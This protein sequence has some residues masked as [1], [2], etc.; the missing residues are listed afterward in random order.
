M[1]RGCCR[2]VLLRAALPLLVGLGVLALTREAAAA[3][4]TT[5]DTLLLA[6]TTDVE[7]GVSPRGAMIRSFLFPGWGQAAAGSYTRGGVFFAIQ[8]SSWYMLL[9]TIARYHQAQDIVARKT[10]IATDSLDRLIAT[11]T[12]AARRLSDPSNY[13]AALSEYPGMIRARALVNSRRQQRQDWITYTLF[14]TLIS[15]VD[16]YVNAHLK[17]FPGDIMTEARRDGSVSFGLR[18]PLPGPAGHP[19]PTATSGAA[20]PPRR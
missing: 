20:R 13:A 18:L 8:G 5:N 4:V 9:R 10:R 6:D 17:D 7:R 11:D 1:K 15:G 3:Q 19:P 16:A 2:S 14:F 12:A